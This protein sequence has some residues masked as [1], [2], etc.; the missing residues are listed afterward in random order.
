[1]LGNF[2]ELICMLGDGINVIYFIRIY[3]FDLFY[4]L[5]KKEIYCEVG[6]VIKLMVLWWLV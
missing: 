1:M 5:K 3:V 2:I 4:R 6:E